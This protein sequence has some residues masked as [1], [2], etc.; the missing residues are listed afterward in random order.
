MIGFY[1][2]LLCHFHL[3]LIRICSLFAFLPE[4]FFQNDFEDGTLELYYLS[5]YCLQK[6]PLSKL[7]GHWV[8]QISGVSRSF[9]ALQLPYQFDQSKMNWFTIIIGSQIFTPMCG[10]HPR[11][12]LGITSNG[13][14]SLQNPTTLPTS[15]PL[16]VFCTSISSEKTTEWFH[17]IISLMGGYLLL[18]LFL[19]PI[20][21]SI[22]SRTLLAKR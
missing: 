18:L 21:V 7:Y 4:R 16:I 12:A 11:S 14:N 1:K 22:T 3:G 19:Y 10:I 5:G 2:D 20:L 15:L 13:W 17:V 6:I 9:P 8:L